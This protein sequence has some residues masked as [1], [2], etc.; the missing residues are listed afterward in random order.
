VWVD[1][2]LSRKFPTTISNCLI[3]LAK[4]SGVHLFTRP[5][6]WKKQKNKIGT[7][8][9]KKT[10]RRF[11]LCVLEIG[12]GGGTGVEV[13]T[14]TG[15]PNTYIRRQFLSTHNSGNFD[16]KT[17]NVIRS[18]FFRKFPLDFFSLFFQRGGRLFSNFLLFLK[19]WVSVLIYTCYC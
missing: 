7:F 16:F 4:E 3:H 11:Y 13:T 5:N 8:F 19:R 18:N 10:P 12:G 2:G 1:Y 14:H 9:K 6:N 17:G 15:G